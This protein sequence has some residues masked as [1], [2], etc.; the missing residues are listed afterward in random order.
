MGGQAQ[1][2][3]AAADPSSGA[4]LP[5]AANQIVRDAGTQAAIYSLTADADAVYGTG[6]VFGAGGN[7]EGTFMADNETGAI[8]W[9]EDC[10]GDTYSASPTANA[11]Y[12]AG[13][14]HY[15]GNIG[16]FPQTSPELDLQPLARLRQDRRRHDHQ[17][18]ARLLQLRRQPAPGTAALVPEVDRGHLHRPEPGR[19][20]DQGQRRRQLRRL[21]R[22]VPAVNAIAQQGLV[23]FGPAS[24][25]PN[26]IAPAS[27]T[28]PY[29]NGQSFS[30]SAVSLR[31][32]QGA[33][34]LDHHL[35]PRQPAPDL[36]GLPRLHG[37][38]GSDHVRPDR[39]QPV[40]ATAEHGLH[41]PDRGARLHAPVPGHR[42]R[43]LRQP[44]Q[45][46]RRHGHDRDGGGQQ[47]L[48]RRGPRRQ[49]DQLLPAR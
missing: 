1:Y 48:R 16:G 23:R 32:R 49:P 22:R 46:Q 8:N 45:H 42:V 21:R 25:A 35:G 18:P 44:G 6:Y 12:V 40:L 11:V 28:T 24:V 33:H 10:H 41:R 15:C 13:H 43:R 14:M 29:Y 30:V 2:G 3:M 5:W 31:G 9:I 26:K 39:R 34:R 37:D 19:L 27:A 36:Q 17:R 38:H 20:V 4:V 7:L 47:P